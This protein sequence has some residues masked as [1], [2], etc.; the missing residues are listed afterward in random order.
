MKGG[1]LRR[2]KFKVDAYIIAH[3]IAEKI[4]LVGIKNITSF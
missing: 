2:I 4:I 3:I 1:L